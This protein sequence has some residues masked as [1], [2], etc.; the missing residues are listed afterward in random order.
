MHIFLDSSILLAFCRSKSGASALIIDYCR[1]KKLTGYIAKKVVAE[2][3]KNNM[4]DE[5]AVGIQRFG[6]VLNRRFLTIVEDGSGEALK[7]A[8]SVI[9]N[10]KDT[11][12][13]VSAKQTP[14]IQIFLS[15]DNGL[16]KPA[17]KSYLKPIEILK[18][19]EFIDRFRS[20]LE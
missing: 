2:V 8:N 12:I 10:P 14:N 7:K 11:P 9:D 15:L 3:Q 4:E 19:G 13:L 18:P 1:R 5:N 6:Y 16:F 20:E 17:V